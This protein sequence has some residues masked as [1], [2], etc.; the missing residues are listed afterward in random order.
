MAQENYC[1]AKTE[2]G[3]CSGNPPDYTCDPRNVDCVSIIYYITPKQMR[4]KFSK[5]R[6]HRREDNRLNVDVKRLG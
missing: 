2:D 5:W 1:P 6:Q 4:E 3:K